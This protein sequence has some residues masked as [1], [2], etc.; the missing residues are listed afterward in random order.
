MLASVP[1]IRA[2]S[3]PLL[4][5][6][7]QKTAYFDA[8][9]EADQGRPTT[10]A[11]FIVERSLRL[12]ELVD[13]EI[14]TRPGTPNMP[15]GPSDDPWR[16]TEAR[17]HDELWSRVSEL[18]QNDHLGSVLRT[19]VEADRPAEHSHSIY[20]ALPNPTP[21]GAAALIT[22]SQ[23]VVVG[24]VL[25]DMRAGGSMQPLVFD[26]DDIIPDLTTEARLRLDGV[27]RLFVKR[28]REAL[29]RP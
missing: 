24:R 26:R 6:A 16:I 11:E 8:L 13:I 9:D 28:A 19:S 15:P 10:F 23:R 22:I 12:M 4:I 3:L 2:T 1:L 25:V 17:I 7:E 18:V 20:L 5:F 29:E 14:Q 21:R 27:A